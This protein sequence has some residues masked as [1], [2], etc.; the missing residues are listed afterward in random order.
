MTT[1][2]TK[3]KEIQDQSLFE[4]QPE[5]DIQRN[6]FLFGLS[7]TS[8]WG[9]NLRWFLEKRLIA[10]VGRVEYISRNNAM[11][12]IIKFLDYYSPKNTDILQEYF[13]PMNRF[14]EFVDSLRGIIQ[15]EHINLLS[16]TIR[17]VPQDKESFLPYAKENSFA[18]VLYVNQGLDENEIKR[19]QMWTR[20]IV[21]LALGYG[22][23]YYLPYQLYPTKE[24]LIKSYLEF[25]EFINRKQKYDPEERFINKLYEQ[26]R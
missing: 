20:G 1:T 8:D 17:Y 6:K 5:K 19:T 9:K 22:G 4:L 12:P 16:I 21:D 13:I 23:S 11:R 15:K 24:H 18:F 10:K 26:Y 14:V 3:T 7:R 25:N 2:Y